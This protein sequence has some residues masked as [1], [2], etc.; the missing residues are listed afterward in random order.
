MR[1]LIRSPEARPWAARPRRVT[2]TI[3][4]I[5]LIFIAVVNLLALAYVKAIP[6]EANSFLRS[7]RANLAHY[8]CEAGIND[9][10]AFITFELKNGREPTPSGPVTRSGSHN[11]WTWNAEIR[12]DALS[13]PS[14][15]AALRF[16]EI[17]SEAF[18]PGM[19]SPSRRIRTTVG[20]E[21]FARYTNYVDKFPGWVYQD[22]LS[23]GTFIEGHVHTNTYFQIRP[24][25]AL[26]SGSGPAFLG[27]VTSAGS[28]PNPWDFD[29][30]NYMETAQAPYDAADNPIPGRYEKIYLH[31]REGLN[32]NVNRIEMPDSAGGLARRAWGD[33]TA[34]PVLQGLHV[35]IDAGEIKGGYYVVGDVKSLRLESAGGT[36]K[37]TI[38]QDVGGVDKTT[39]ILEGHEGGG[40]LNGLSVPMGSTGIWLPDQT[41]VVYPGIANGLLHCTG[42][43]DSLEGTN[44]GAHTI[45]ADLEA[46]KKITITGDIL[47]A[48]T[49]AGSRTTGPRDVLGLVCYQVVISETVPRDPGDPLYLYM[50]Y[51]A[52]K[53]ETWPDGGF[54]VENYADATRGRGS[55]Y[56]HGAAGAG[57]LFPTGVG[58][59]Y[60]FGYRQ[61]FDQ[62]V[63]NN[64]PPFYPTTGKL[65]IRS[66][67]EEDGAL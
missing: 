60:G 18:G 59:S 37:I 4:Y 21:T 24:S 43:I 61:Y 46:E 15:D 51:L 30:V 29:G 16:Y 31:G 26:Y 55:F 13:P 7:E 49:P 67:R 40:D 1:L 65:P 50:S 38:V 62:N 48:D 66:W 44:F 39:V 14:G 17:S 27:Y 42:D 33:D 10:L 47:R 5:A 52:G 3:L 11:G 22:L 45:S 56:L 2:G 35:N 34:Q 36:A 64:P 20:E 32:T 63:V 28:A 6:T 54:V 23:D 8:A 53:S 9:C 19:T 57:T 12:P 41:P 25:D 58:S